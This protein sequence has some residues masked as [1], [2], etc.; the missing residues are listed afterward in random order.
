MSFLSVTERDRWI[1]MSMNKAKLATAVSKECY[2]DRDTVVSVLGAL[3]NVVIR[4]IGQGESI[5]IFNGFK[6]EARWRNESTWIHPMTHE[7]CIARAGWTC[8]TKA[9]SKFTK[10][11]NGW[12]V[13]EETFDFDEESEDL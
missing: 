9:N 8:R 6:L 3:E 5:C 10:R 13:K 12:D 7:P 4:T 11:I 1:F 2:V